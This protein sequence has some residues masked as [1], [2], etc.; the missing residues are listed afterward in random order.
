M[1][2]PIYPHQAFDKGVICPICYSGEIGKVLRTTANVVASLQLL[3][4]KRQE[5]FVCLSLDSNR[6]LLTQRIITVG[7]LD[8]TLVHPREVFAGAIADRA[9]SVIVA[10]NHPSGVPKPSI[11]DIETTRQLLAASKVLGVP[12][13]DHI[14]ITEESYFSFKEHHMLS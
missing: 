7:L 2:R 13:K 8:A 12:I 1:E 3:G 9:H 10:H 11:D 4:D 6:R 5:Y 14:I